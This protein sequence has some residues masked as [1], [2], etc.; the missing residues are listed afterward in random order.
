MWHQCV[1]LVELLLTPYKRRF[2]QRTAAISGAWYDT[3][4]DGEGWLLDILADG[5]ALV[6]WFTY[7]PEGN[8]AW[9]LNTG[10]VEGDTIRFNLLVPSGTDFGPTFDPD[11]VNRP[12]WGR[13]TFKFDDCNS[14][15][16]NYD[17]P[18]PGYGSGS[19]ALTRL[20]KLS[21]LECQ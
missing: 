1:Q 14:G 5:R 8:Q 4:H 18:L 3:S 20:T 13:A 16:M 10:Q 2:C 17:S 6:N 7:D 11:R 15:T 19:L 21:G 9:F 12:P